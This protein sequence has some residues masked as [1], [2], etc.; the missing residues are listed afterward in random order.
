MI[1]HFAVPS[2]GRPLAMA[3][4]DRCGAESRPVVDE[5]MLVWWELL[6]ECEDRLERLRRANIG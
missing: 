1:L 2:P 6:H 5:R 4:C 3:V